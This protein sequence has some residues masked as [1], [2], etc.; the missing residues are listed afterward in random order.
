MNN[1]DI[2]NNEILSK[3]GDAKR[4]FF[5]GT[6][7]FALPIL[8]VLIADKAQTEVVGAITKPDARI[9][10]GGSKSRSLKVN[11]VK[12]A[13][14]SHGIHLWQPT[15]L[16]EELREEILSLKPD[17]LV[18][19]SYGKILPPSYL[20]I[21]PF[22][23]I[24]IHASLLPHYRGASP[25]QN[26]L[27][28]GDKETGITIIQIDEGLDTGPMLA[29]A[30]I[31]IQDK[32]TTEKLTDVLSTLGANTTLQLLPDFFSGKMSPQEQDHDAA[33]LCQ[34]KTS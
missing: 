6:G 7:P 27:L 31:P 16:T 11:P 28:S 24:N 18:V 5:M 19:V 30:K 25:I 13:V 9:G 22:G 32:D 26:S 4:I 15:Q 8:E 23:A 10:R 34:M 33:T 29:Q 12:E 20:T 14:L 2:R 21:A 17:L 3:E 1:F